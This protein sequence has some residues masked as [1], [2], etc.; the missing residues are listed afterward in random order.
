MAWLLI[1]NSNNRTKFRMGD[2]GGLHEW[3]AVMPTH[4]LTAESIQPLIDG[5]DFSGVVVASVVPGKEGVLRSVFANHAYHRLTHESPL[6]YGFELA[7][8]EQIGHDRLANAVALNQH[9]AKPGIALDF[10][11]AV[12][13]SVISAAGNFAGG[14]IAPGMECMTEYLAK[15]TALLPKVEAVPYSSS[16]GKNT[17]D[18]MR[19]G[20][21]AGQRGMV[22][23]ILR[24][25]ISEIGGE[26]AVVA[27][28]GGATFAAHGLTEISSV[29]LDLTLEGLRLVAARVFID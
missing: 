26:V 23:E 2:A 25:M 8:P 12:T 14:A 20:A 11:T 13:F 1:D 7:E 21:V 4:D 22:R 9:Y 28:G 19:I 16:I 17:I 18:A 15:K 3:H 24:E 29:N 27:T 6:G 10:G 5:L